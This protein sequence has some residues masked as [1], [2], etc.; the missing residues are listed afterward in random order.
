MYFDN[1]ELTCPETITFRIIIHLSFHA[2]LA[3]NATSSDIVI[4]Q[5]V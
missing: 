4:T 1:I 3:D 5:I 2:Q